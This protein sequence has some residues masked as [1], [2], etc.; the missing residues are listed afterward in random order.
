[1][2]DSGEEAEWLRWEGRLGVLAV[3]GYAE[4]HVTEWAILR[5]VW[6]VTARLM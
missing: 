3:H 4:R 1:M 5:E 6:S 2:T